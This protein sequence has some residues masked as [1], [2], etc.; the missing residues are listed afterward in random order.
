MS[1]NFS[2]KT[3]SP[4][5]TENIGKK[6]GS[7][8]KPGDIVCLE[9]DLGA[10][11]TC[12]TR[13]IAM[14][15]EVDPS[16]VSSPTFVLAQEYSGKFKVCHMDL[17][18]L[19]SS[20]EFDD[21]GLYEYLEGDNVVIMEWPQAANDVIFDKDRLCVNITVDQLSLERIFKFTAY[22]VRS[23]FI[24]KEMNADAHLSN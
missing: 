19:N 20:I 12:F 24:V 7:L 9:G 3:S 4:V 2:I 21:I 11:K 8:L 1:V 13:G 17:Y 15:L 14:G 16:Y 23:E 10:G 6:L 18:R 22:G 5:Q